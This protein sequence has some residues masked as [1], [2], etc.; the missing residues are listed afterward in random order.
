MTKRPWL[1]LDF[2]PV[3]ISA[4]ARRAL[5]GGATLLTLVAALPYAQKNPDR[6]RVQRGADP[7]DWEAYYDMGIELLQNNRG[8]EAEAAFFW[9]SRVRPDRA[10]PL[11]ARFI[12]F[13]VRDSRNFDK[14]GDYLRDD[15]RVLRDPQVQRADL[16]RYAA[17][18][19]SPF[20]HQGLL[21]FLFARL[22]GRW[23]DDQLTAG[24]IALGEGKLSIALERFGRLVAADQKKYGYLRFVRASAFANSAQFDSAAGQLSSLLTQ[25]RGE[26]D[27]T[28]GSMYQS[29]EL[30]EFALGLLHEAMRR[31]TAAKEAF[32]RAVAENAAF[33]PAHAA[34]GRMAI[35]ARDSSTALVEF[36]LAVETEPDD[37]VLRIGYGQALM[38]ARRPKDAAAQFQKA[39]ELE[40]YYAEPVFLLA[41]AL[42]ETGDAASAKQRFGQFLELASRSD[43]HRAEAERK[44]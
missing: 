43:P 27:K 31:P 23:K 25:L 13:W 21:M 4:S 15:E 42:E 20:V 6:P 12:A 39:V 33:S 28:T 37:V 38:L 41:T 32:G 22:P 1:V 24:W 26:D 34:L 19:R 10:E 18:R 11:Y 35:A 2:N 44:K 29:K 30:L 16:L 9:A 7:N 14:F 8:A 3:A 5:L 40:P 36:G 17:L